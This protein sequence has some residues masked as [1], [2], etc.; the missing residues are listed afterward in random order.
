MWKPTQRQADVARIDVMAIEDQASELRSSTRDGLIEFGDVAD[1]GA[2]SSP[3]QGTQR[4]PI[5]ARTAAP[6][7]PTTSPGPRRSLRKKI[8]TRPVSEM[9]VR[10][11]AETSITTDQTGPVSRPLWRSLITAMKP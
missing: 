2:G 6:T 3:S 10:T 11:T 7:R 1:V 9:T 5:A 8:R 4:R